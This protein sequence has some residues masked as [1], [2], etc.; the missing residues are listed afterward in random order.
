MTRKCVSGERI[1]W[2]V[3][4]LWWSWMDVGMDVD[5]Y[6]R[7]DKGYKVDGSSGFRLSAANSG[8]N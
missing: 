1:F 2:K 4:N 8:W 3:E 6:G 7:L 5:G